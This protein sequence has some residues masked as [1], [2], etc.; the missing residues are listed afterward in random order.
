MDSKRRPKSTL[1]AFMKVRAQEF[2]IQVNPFPL[3][4]KEQISESDCKFKRS[5]SSSDSSESDHS[6]EEDLNKPK[7][8]F[9]LNDS[10]RESSMLK[11]TQNDQLISPL[12]QSQSRNPKN[13]TFINPSIKKLKEKSILNTP[14][15]LKEFKY[16]RKSQFTFVKE[17]PN[18]E[19]KE[20]HQ[21][22]QFAYVNSRENSARSS[23]TSVGTAQ[24]SRSLKAEEN[25]L[26]NQR[27][28]IF[29]KEGFESQVSYKVDFFSY[30]DRRTPALT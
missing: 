22:S 23:G 29:Q 5:F 3:E 2:S 30:L 18:N 6:S 9:S 28:E 8:N 19:Y 24:S 13:Q 26:F 21:M 1:P 16:R 11:I 15:Y 4:Q 25:I 27:D 12:S 20:I 14:E 17:G 10:K 7:E